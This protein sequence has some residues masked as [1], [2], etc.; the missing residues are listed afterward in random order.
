L[1]VA[2][3]WKLACLMSPNMQIACVCLLQIQA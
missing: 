1:P 3:H 2:L